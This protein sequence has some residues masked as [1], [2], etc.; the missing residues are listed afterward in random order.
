LSPENDLRGIPLVI[1]V[2]F[3]DLRVVEPAVYFSKALTSGILELR[4]LLQH[5]P[6]S[7][8]AIS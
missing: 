6:V 1:T 3:P 2:E 4:P 5:S 7:T 8:V